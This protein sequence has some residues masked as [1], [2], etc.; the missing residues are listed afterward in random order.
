VILIS[1]PNRTHNMRTLSHLTAERQTE[2]SQ[3]TLDIYAPSA[4]TL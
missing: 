2:I 4:H 1:S 3:E